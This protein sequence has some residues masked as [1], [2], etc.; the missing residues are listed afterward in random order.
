MGIPCDRGSYPRT[1]LC[2]RKE[3]LLRNVHISVNIG[4]LA[5]GIGARK[6]S[7]SESEP[8]EAKTAERR[9]VDRDLALAP[10]PGGRR[11]HR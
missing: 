3:L 2:V 1:V 5:G 7:E 10:Q 11:V 6:D 4:S 8:R 9:A